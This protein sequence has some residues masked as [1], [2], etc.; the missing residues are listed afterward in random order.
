M[1]R[2][3]SKSGE[4]T[5]LLVFLA[6]AAIFWI[7]AFTYPVVPLRLPLEGPLFVWFAKLI[8]SYPAL[9]LSV[10]LGFVILL[11]I[12]LNLI[13]ISN[14][15]I[16]RKNLLP[17]I[18]T[19]LLLSWNHSFQAMN[20]VVPGSFF[21]L[22]SIYYLLSAYNQQAPFTQLFTA[23]IMIGVA[24]MFYL[25]FMLLIIGLF[26]SLL[27]LRIN[28]VRE[29]AIPLIAFSL[30]FI[31]WISVAYLL[32][33]P[34]PLIE[35]TRKTGFQFMFI[36][37]LRSSAIYWVMACWFFLLITLFSSVNQLSAK[38]ISIR[39]KT[40]IIIDF[41]FIAILIMASSGH[42]FLVVNSLLV[43]FL[44][45][46]FALYIDNYKRTGILD[47]LFTVFTIS[48]ILLRFMKL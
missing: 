15:L 35:A 40:Y 30:P 25:P 5:Q 27:T 24:S 36:N 21:I 29:W 14:D 41:L 3:I 2:L 10:E 42:V 19:V 13:L 46:F 11:A 18:L 37:E 16:Q 43:L 23:G 8:S 28:S 20:P 48:L 7:P 12:L 39:R 31:Y 17:A 1:L 44:S 9:S 6:I 45:A 32:D 38:L 4:F 47:I 34:F 26:F 22:I 33:K